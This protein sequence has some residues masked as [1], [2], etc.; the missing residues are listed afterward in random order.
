MSPDHGV[1]NI[2]FVVPKLE[3]IKKKKKIKIKFFF[4]TK[5]STGGLFPS[6]SFFLHTNYS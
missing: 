2:L 5:I 6:L 3:K 1:H 4:S